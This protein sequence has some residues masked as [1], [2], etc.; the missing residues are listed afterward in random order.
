LGDVRLR[1]SAGERERIMNEA[2][3]PG[4]SVAEVARRHAMNAN[5][6]FKWL[7][8]A[9]YGRQTRERAS[10]GGAVIDMAKPL[11][12]VPLGVFSRDDEAGAAVTLPAPRTPPPAS[13]VVSPTHLP[14]TPRLEERAGV[15]EVELA[16]GSRVRVDAF[17]N[18]RALCR[19]LRAMKA[20]S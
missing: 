13:A 1:R 5:L 6:L 11:E 10:G 19:V 9:G 16:G 12:F 3:E 7:R 14:A 4:A 20:T 8:E 15:I 17:V 18:E 2:L